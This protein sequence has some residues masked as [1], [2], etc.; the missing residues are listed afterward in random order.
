M[1]LVKW[2]IIG[3]IV[4]VPIAIVILIFRKPN[5]GGNEP[6]IVE[7]LKVLTTTPQTREQIATRVAKNTTGKKLDF[8]NLDKDLGMLWERGYVDLSTKSA[9]PDTVMERGAKHVETFSLS[10][11]GVERTSWIRNNGAQHPTLPGLRKRILKN[12]RTK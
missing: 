11:K 12:R 4:L 10:P 3:A 1:E 6:D 8:K 5:E 7:Y 2:I 9:E